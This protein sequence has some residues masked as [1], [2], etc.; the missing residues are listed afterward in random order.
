MIDNNLETIYVDDQVRQYKALWTLIK[1][2]I[3][4]SLEIVYSSD[5]QDV[6]I[7]RLTKSRTEP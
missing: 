4:K 2:Q 7:L 6:Q 3:G 1:S 5:N